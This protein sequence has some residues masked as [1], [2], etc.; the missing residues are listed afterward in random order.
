MRQFLALAFGQM[1]KARFHQDDARCFARA[2]QAE[3]GAS[4]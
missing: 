3:N 2:C 4:G 1:I